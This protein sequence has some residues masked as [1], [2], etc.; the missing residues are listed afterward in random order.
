MAGGRCPDGP[1]EED[2]VLDPIGPLLQGLT[3]KEKAG[4]ELFTVVP[5]E[6]LL[7]RPIQVLQLRRLGSPLE[8]MP[9]LMGERLPRLLAPIEARREMSQ[10]REGAVIQ[11]DAALH[12]V[13]PAT[14]G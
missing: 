11:D 7:D 13:H 5:G 10:R 8:M 6:V 1:I 4:I 3:V 9:Q 14:D 12:R 2:V